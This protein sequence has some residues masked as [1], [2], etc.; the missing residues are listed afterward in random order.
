MLAVHAVSSKM[1]GNWDGARVLGLS[2]DGMHL[3]AKF[4][5]RAPEH[6]AQQAARADARTRRAAAEAPGVLAVLRDA[7]REQASYL[8]GVA[9]TRDFSMHKEP[10]PQSQPQPQPQPQPV[11]AESAQ[12]PQPQEPGVQVPDGTCT[13]AKLRETDISRDMHLRDIRAEIERRTQEREARG[14]ET[15]QLQAT[16]RTLQADV[17]ALRREAQARASAEEAAV[18][19]AQRAY[20]TLQTVLVATRRALATHNSE[21]AAAKHS[22][23]PQSPRSH[24]ASTQIPVHPGLQEA[25]RWHDALQCVDSN[26]SRASRRDDGG[27]QSSWSET[28]ESESMATV[29]AGDDGNTRRK[30]ARHGD[31]GRGVQSSSQVTLVL[32]DTLR[33][34]NLLKSRASEERSAR[35]HSRLAHRAEVAELQQEM[36]AL[37]AQLEE[38]NHARAQADRFVALLEEDRSQL[39]NQVKLGHSHTQHDQVRAAALTADIKG[40]QDQVVEQRAKVQE[41]SS[42]CHALEGQLAQANA[43]AQAAA[44]ATI[45]A[46]V[47][48]GPGGDSGGGAEMEAQVCMLSS[49]ALRCR[50]ALQALASA[51]RKLFAGSL[52]SCSPCFLRARVALARS[53]ALSAQALSA[54]LTPITRCLTPHTSHARRSLP[55]CHGTAGTALDHGVSR[56]PRWRQGSRRH[57][58]GACLATRCALALSGAAR[59]R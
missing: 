18:A 41:L 50:L 2:E 42:R 44:A 27:G 58:R 6:A 19:A 31:G 51:I 46:A 34:L 22:Q 48:R 45:A 1:A 33:E 37:R 38:V 9:A 25:P 20:L 15:E 21:L 5:I 10:Q 36:T 35:E 4:N 39:S 16:V 14:R 24:N 17:D 49:R 56:L 47:E 59:G 29:T 28:S 13:H 23:R 57:A 43:D 54:L 11:P 55:V 40:M 26:A 8:E 52:S 30:P 7:G 3:L 32:K 53:S 12:R